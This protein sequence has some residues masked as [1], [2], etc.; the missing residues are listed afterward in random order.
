MG[1]EFLLHFNRSPGFQSK[2]GFRWFYM[3]VNGNECHDTPML[4][5]HKRMPAG[6]G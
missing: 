2:A 6:M 1:H 3:C 5:E 4:T